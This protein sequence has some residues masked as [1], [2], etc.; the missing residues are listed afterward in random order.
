MVLAITDGGK[1]F[2]ADLALVRLLSCVSSHMDEKIPFL[3]KY[4]A[5]IENATIEEILS[6]M[7][8]F[9]M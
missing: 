6:G 3:C 2:E 8:R 5:T 9:Y 4:L 7:S 1:S